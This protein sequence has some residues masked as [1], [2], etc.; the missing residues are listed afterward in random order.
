MYMFNRTKLKCRTSRTDGK[1]VRRANRETEVGLRAAKVGTV[2]RAPKINI[3]KF[4]NQ[5]HQ[6]K[7]PGK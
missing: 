3:I 7:H 5:V 2:K 1:Q 6:T 4:T